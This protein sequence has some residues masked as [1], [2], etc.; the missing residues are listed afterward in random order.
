LAAKSSVE[1]LPTCQQGGLQEQVLAGK[2]FQQTLPNC[3]YWFFR[4]APT[5]R[6]WEHWRSVWHP[7][8]PCP[9]YATVLTCA[10]HGQYWLDLS[11]WG[12][13]SSILLQ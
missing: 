7:M 8:S 10:H 1:S 12:L 13:H 11:R 9:P 4:T 2:A 3:S 5:T 6:P